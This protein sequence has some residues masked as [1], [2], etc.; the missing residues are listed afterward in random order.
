[1]LVLNPNPTPA[2]VFSPSAGFNTPSAYPVYPN[3]LGGYRKKSFI[4]KSKTYKMTKNKMYKKSRKN[5]SK[6]MKKTK[7]Y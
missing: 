6:K 5:N 1:M 4:N 7:K 3:L 2:V